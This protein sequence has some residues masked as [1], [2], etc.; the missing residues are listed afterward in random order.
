MFGLIIKNLY[1]SNYYC[2]FSQIFHIP[3]KPRIYC[4][5]YI[6]MYL[7]QNEITVRQRD[8][9]GKTRNNKLEK[10]S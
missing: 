9:Q 5:T 2:L 1:N 10:I 3:R 6:C 7:L 4:V 8:R